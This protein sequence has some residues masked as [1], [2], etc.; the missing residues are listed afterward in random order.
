MSKDKSSGIQF[1]FK[2]SDIQFKSEFKFKW[3]GIQRAM[4]QKINRVGQ[5]VALEEFPGPSSN[6]KVG[7]S[8]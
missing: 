2:S 3:S 6:S 7:G 4:C 5:E 8:T 1:K